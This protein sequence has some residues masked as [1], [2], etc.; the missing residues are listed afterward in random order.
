MVKI[1][2][3]DAQILS[4]ATIIARGK[5][6]EDALEN[7]AKVSQLW[8]RNVAIE[9]HQKCLESLALQILHNAAGL[10]SGGMPSKTR[11]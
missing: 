4:E 8:N 1:V 6:L 5:T 9:V 11:L 10:S 3:I 7:V 2:N